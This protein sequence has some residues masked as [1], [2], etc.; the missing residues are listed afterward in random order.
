MLIHEIDQCEDEGAVIPKEIRAMVQNLDPSNDGWNMPLIDELLSFLDELPRNSGQTN[1]EPNELDEIRRLSKSPTTDKADVAL[2]T[3]YEDRIDAAWRGRLFGCALGLPYE[4]LGC[5]SHEG[6][7][8]GTQR[9]QDHL[10]STLNFPI[11]DFAKELPDSEV[12]WGESRS[13]T[14]S[15]E[16]NLTMTFILRLRTCV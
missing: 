4:R 11:I 10:R 1:A 7:N 16:W 14:R 2:D 13:V 15:L 9:V 6:R 3:D 5:A 12:V 8:N